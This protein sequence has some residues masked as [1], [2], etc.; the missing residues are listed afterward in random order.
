MLDIRN[1]SFSYGKK[2][3]LS[4][5]SLHLDDGEI[6]AVMGPSGCGKS[7]LLSIIAGLKKAERGEI[8][9]TH[10]RPAFV[11]QEPRLFPWLTVQENL[12][13]P[14]DRTRRSEAAV[15]AVLDTVMLTDA[16]DLYPDELSG[17]MKSRVALSRALLFDGDLYLLDEPFAALD[18]ELREVLAPRLRAHLKERGAAAILVTHQTSDAVRIADRTLTLTALPTGS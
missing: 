6:L 14:L 16:A 3:V 4:D 18:E 13:A 8:V 11:F 17:G 15:R 12:L 2:Q 5:F 1:I 7:T 9:S 10:T